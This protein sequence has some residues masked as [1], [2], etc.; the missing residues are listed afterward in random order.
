M[1][2]GLL[3]LAP[4]HAGQ[5]GDAV[6]R[7]ERFHAGRGSAV[8]RFLGD[9][10]LGIGGGRHLR[11]V[12]HTEDLPPPRDLAHL[13]ADGLRRLAPTFASTSSKTSTGSSSA[14]DRLEGEHHAR[15]FARRGNGAERA[16]W[17]AGL[18]AN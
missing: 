9:R 1:P 17:L 12:R 6:I 15:Q 13:V 4:Q 18:G 2:A 14:A 5:L 3:T 7:V 8:P 11:Q 16:R 10:E